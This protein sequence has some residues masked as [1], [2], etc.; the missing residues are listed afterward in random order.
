MD[1]TGKTK[2][3]VKARL[4]LLEHCRRS[5]LHIQESANNKSLKPKA[6][7]SFTMEQKRKICEWVKNLKMPDGYAS[8]LGKRA[9]IE[10]GILHGMKSHDCHVFMEQLLSIAFCGL[11]ENIWKP[12]AEISLFFKDLCSSTLRVENLVWM[13]KNIVVITNKLEKILPPGFFDVMEHLPIHLV[14][15]ALLGG[16]VQYRWMYPFE[17]SIGKSKRGIKNKH[18]VEG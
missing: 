10:R 5:E 2:D 15:E 18:R 3:N 9:D 7:Y 13:A 6:S 4:D 16:P 8:N 14:H 17:R 12:M 11:P 1:V